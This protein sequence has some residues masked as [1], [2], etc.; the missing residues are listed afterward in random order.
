M[1]SYYGGGSLVGVEGR[2]GG[3]GVNERLSRGLNWDASERH[4]WRTSQFMHT[5]GI[6]KSCKIGLKVIPHS[7]HN[8]YSRHPSPNSGSPNIGL[9]KT[10]K[11][12]SSPIQ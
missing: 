3:G 2:T 5:G 9:L 11:Y 4:S 1:C 6:P 7:P 8:C 12:F 10:R